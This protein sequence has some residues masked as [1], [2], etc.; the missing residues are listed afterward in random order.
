VEV[1]E[2]WFF[3]VGWQELLL[4]QR[5]GL[6]SYLSKKEEIIS[7]NVGKLYGDRDIYE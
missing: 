3:F 1:L 6:W 5:F 7:M 4:L 2:F